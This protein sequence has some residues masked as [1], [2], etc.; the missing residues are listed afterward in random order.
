[1]NKFYFAVLLLLVLVSCASRKEI[2]YLQ[3]SSVELENLYT[4]HTPRIQ[5][6][7]LLTITISSADI[8]ATQPFNQQ[9]AYQMQAAAASDLAFKPTYLVDANGEIDFPVLGKVKVGG[10]SRLE[11]TDRIRE[12]LKQYIVDPG[13]NLTFANFKVTVLGEVRTPGTYTMKQERVT[14]LEA[15]GL[16]GDMTIKGQ[17]NNVLLIREQNGEKQMQRLNLLSDSVLNSPYYYLAQNDVIYVEPNN[18]QV[19][20]SR[21]GQ[22]TSVWISITSLMI[23]I[24]TLVVTN[25]KK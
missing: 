13:V 22:D 24:I 17:R 14:V 12:R 19:R 7:D 11:A 1:M 18:S 3:P 16:A 21:F 15:L 8:K 5:Q 4:K 9:N 23:T 10:L 6:E 20:N 25:S 2:I